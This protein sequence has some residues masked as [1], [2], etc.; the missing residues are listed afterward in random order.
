V[1]NLDEVKAL[2]DDCIRMQLS[3]PPEM[4]Y[5]D[6]RDIKEAWNGIGADSTPKK[7]RDI[8]SRRFRVFAPAAL[9]HDFE[10]ELILKT[11]RQ[12]GPAMGEPLRELADDRFYANMRACAESAAGAWN[13]RRY[14]LL[15]DAFICWRT[16]RRL[17]RIKP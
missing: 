11:V 8:L 5:A 3:M 4:V 9:I 2:L 16:V 17:G 12:L 1:S 7:I 10:Y 13:P 6:I 15:Y 14:A